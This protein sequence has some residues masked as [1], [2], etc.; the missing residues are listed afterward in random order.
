MREFKEIILLLNR[1][2]LSNII[3]ICDFSIEP[4]KFINSYQIQS[5]SEILLFVFFITIDVEIGKYFLSY[6][7]SISSLLVRIQ[8]GTHIK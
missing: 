8:R 6:K 3:E 2:E 5:F 1:G 4:Y 7:F